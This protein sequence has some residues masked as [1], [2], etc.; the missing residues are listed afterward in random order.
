MLLSAWWVYSLSLSFSTP[1]CLIIWAF[2]TGSTIP[3][4]KLIWHSQI[5]EETMKIFG[6]VDVK[7]HTLDFFQTNIDESIRKCLNNRDVKIFVSIVYMFVTIK[8][9]IWTI[10]CLSLHSLCFSLWKT[11]KEKYWVIGTCVFMTISLSQIAGKNKMF[12][13]R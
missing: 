12:D 9:S 13:Q 2:Y 5:Q 3:V 7:L 11:W 6:Q 10:L 8:G 4:W 1:V